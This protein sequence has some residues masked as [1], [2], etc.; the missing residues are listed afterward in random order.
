MTKNV[1]YSKK[2]LHKS[3]IFT[4]FARYFVKLCPFWV[5]LLMELSLFITV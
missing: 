5:G 4:T 1:K 2:Y 3:K